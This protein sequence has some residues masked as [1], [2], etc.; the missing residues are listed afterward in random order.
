MWQLASTLNRT[1]WGLFLILFWWV[2]LLGVRKTVCLR[3]ASLGVVSRLHPTS[4][5]V[6]CLCWYTKLHSSHHPHVWLAFLLQAPVW[7]S[8]VLIN[9]SRTRGDVMHSSSLSS[10]HWKA[11]HP[12]GWGAR[13]ATQLPSRCVSVTVLKLLAQ[14]L[15]AAHGFPGGSGG[16]ESACNVGDPGL[17]CG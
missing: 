7:V 8:Q 4:E 11:P 15:P 5:A 14:Q 10:E 12:T 13:A 3:T 17:I 2:F 16:K 9:H 6:P 1:A